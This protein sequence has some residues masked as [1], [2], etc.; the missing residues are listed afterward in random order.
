MEHKPMMSVEPPATRWSCAVAAAPENRV[1]WEAWAP[2]MTDVRDRS[3][4]WGR[5][6]PVPAAIPPKSDLRM[7]IM[8][9]SGPGSLRTG[10]GV[11]WGRAREENPRVS[12]SALTL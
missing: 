4:R 12:F 5:Q 10:W 11:G 1:L 9:A 8:M 7:S 2:S 3:W 6:G